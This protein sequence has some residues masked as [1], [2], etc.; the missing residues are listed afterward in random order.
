MSARVCLGHRER[1]LRVGAS[2]LGWRLDCPG[3]T[4]RAGCLALQPGTAGPAGKAEVQA[5]PPTATMAPTTTPP[6]FPRSTADSWCPPTP[7][8]ACGWRGKDCS[9]G[10]SGELLQEAPGASGFLGC[11]WCRTR[12]PLSY[13][14]GV[15]WVWTGRAGLALSLGACD[16]QQ[17]TSCLRASVS[18]CVKAQKGNGHTR[19][20]QM[21][22][23][24]LPRSLVLCLQPGR[25]AALT[26]CFLVF[27]L[28]GDLSAVSPEK[29]TMMETPSTRGSSPCLPGMD[30]EGAQ[31]GP[32]DYCPREPAPA[33]RLPGLCLCT[34]VVGPVSTDLCQPWLQVC[35][36]LPV[37]AQPGGAHG[38]LGA[39]LLAHS[40][41]S[42]PAL[43]TVRAGVHCPL[44]TPEDGGAGWL[45]GC[46]GGPGGHRA[47]AG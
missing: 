30:G 33:F 12:G 37:W 3:P 28:Q 35:R 22:D 43:R 23:Y 8:P 44:G 45:R 26:V 27:G 42:P 4:L 18:P 16:G 10:P 14:W 6:S 41:L 25:T 13:V 2:S 38:G 1:L 29:K 32:A 36:V 40:C 17:F 46:E 11:A 31:W 21:S 9:L 19:R 39:G 34:P 5:W 20:H 15:E 7:S 24:V 47:A